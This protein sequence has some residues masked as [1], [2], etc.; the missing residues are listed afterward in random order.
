MLNF[1]PFG[2]EQDLILQHTGRIGWQ[3][4]TYVYIVRKKVL[5]LYELG[6]P[7]Y[8]RTHTSLLTDIQ[9]HKHPTV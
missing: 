3:L 2:L 4:V 5:N 8:I 7:L 6:L 1:T 9:M